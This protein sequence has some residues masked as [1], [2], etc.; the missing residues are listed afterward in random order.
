MGK[1]VKV[2]TKCGETFTY[3]HDQEVEK[4]EIVEAKKEV[5][6]LFAPNGGVLA[7]LWSGNGWKFI[8]DGCESYDI[9]SPE[10]IKIGYIYKAYLIGE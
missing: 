7:N 5:N 8:E 2:T 1:R 6:I 4:A 10:G 3:D 9:V